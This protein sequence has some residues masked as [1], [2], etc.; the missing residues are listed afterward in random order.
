MH[1][2]LPPKLSLRLFL[3][4]L[5]IFSKRNPGAY[6]CEQHLLSHNNVIPPLAHQ[7]I[8]SEQ[9]HQRQ[10]TKHH[11]QNLPGE[12]VQRGF[13]RLNLTDEALLERTEQQTQILQ[14]ICSD[15]IL[16]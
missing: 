1:H 7:S 10:L 5:V 6:V 2:L 3:S 12:P 9:L 4:P 14:S 8:A 16:L 13:L 15:I 11:L